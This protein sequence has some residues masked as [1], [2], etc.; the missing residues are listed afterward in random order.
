M[1]EAE[2][3]ALV[4]PLEGRG[5]GE[6]HFSK[7]PLLI[8]LGPVKLEEVWSH[9]E[10]KR[11]ELHYCPECEKLEKKGTWR[12][13]PATMP[14]PVPQPPPKPKKFF[15]RYSNVYHRY[16]TCPAWQKTKREFEKIPGMA[17]AFP[18][19]TFEDREEAEMFWQRCPE[20]VKADDLDAY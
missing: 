2:P 9:G 3:L 1:A 6:Y 14:A 11:R 15:Q 20:C 7:C 18:L 5:V 4:T 13:K 8:R 16:D 12:V 10:A 19:E 17:D